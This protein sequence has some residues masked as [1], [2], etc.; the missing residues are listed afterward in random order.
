MKNIK[1]GV[2]TLSLLSGAVLAGETPSTTNVPTPPVSKGM[3]ASAWSRVKGAC[4]TVAAVPGQAWTLAK[5]NPKTSIALGVAA[6]AAAVLTYKNWKSVK[7]ACNKA[8]DW[9]SKNKL[10]TAGIFTAVVATVAACRAG[11]FTKAGS[12]LKSLVSSKAPNAT[13]PTT[14]SAPTGTPATPASTPKTN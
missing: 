12:W 2:L 11:Y 3:F 5:A 6:V 10:A 7:G 8:V 1:L 14:T 9:V 13:V 4:G